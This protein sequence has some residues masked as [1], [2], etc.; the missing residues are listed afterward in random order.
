[1]AIATRLVLFLALLSVALPAI[2]QQQQR[3]MPR[4]SVTI[5]AGS[6]TADVKVVVSGDTTVEPDEP[7][8]VTISSP[9]LQIGTATA[10]GT[11]I[12]DDGI[13]APVLSVTAPTRVKN[14]TVANFTI[15]RSGDKAQADKVR[16]AIVPLGATPAAEDDFPAVLEDDFSGSTLGDE[17]CA[18]DGAMET[19][20]A[21]DGCP[22][23]PENA[24]HG[25]WEADLVSVS[26]G[27][28]RLS[29]DHDAGAWTS[30]Q[31]FSKRAFRGGLLR[32]AVNYPAGKGGAHAVWRAPEDHY[33]GPGPRSGQIVDS[34]YLGKTSGDRN[35][36][37][38]SQLQYSGPDSDAYPAIA[39]LL[40]DGTTWSGT[41]RA[42]STRW[43]VGTDGVTRFAFQVG[44]TE[45]W[46]PVQ[47]DWPPTQPWTLQ[48]EDEFGNPETIEYPGGGPA[49][50]FDRPFRLVLQA[51]VGDADSP[52]CT[53]EESCPD[54]S[55]LDGA[56][57]LVDFVRLYQ[58][59]TGEAVIQPGQDQAIVPVQTR[60]AAVAGVRNFRFVMLDADE[61]SISGSAGSADVALDPAGEPGVNHGKETYFLDFGLNAGGFT[62]SFGT[63][64]ENGNAFVTGGTAKNDTVTGSGGAVGGWTTD[65]IAPPTLTDPLVVENK[66][67][68]EA[69]WPSQADMAGK[70][71]RIIFPT[72][73]TCVLPKPGSSMSMGDNTYFGGTKT[74]PAHNIYITGG[75][76]ISPPPTP[77]TN[78]SAAG[79]PSGP[80][81]RWMDGIGYWEGAHVD[82]KFTCRDAL[83]LTTL[84]RYE[85]GITL[86]GNQPD[87][88]TPKIF[89]VNSILENTV[90]CGNKGANHGDTIHSQGDSAGSTRP[91]LTLQNVVL[92]TGAQGMFID[93]GSNQS[94]I[95]H[96]VNKLV[97]DHVQVYN[98]T[99]YTRIPNPGTF[100]DIYWNVAP[101]QGIWFYNTWL[102]DGATTSPS[103]SGFTSAGCA[104]YAS[105]AGVRTSGWCRGKNP[106]GDPVT[107]AN[108]GRYYSRAYFTGGNQP[109]DIKNARVPRLDHT[110]MVGA[111]MQIAIPVNTTRGKQRYVTLGFSARDET[112]AGQR[113]FDIAGAV[114]NKGFDIYGNAGARDTETRI[115][116]PV[117]VGD[118]GYLRLTLTGVT[119]QAQINWMS[120]QRPTVSVT[121]DKAVYNEGDTITATLRRS[122]PTEPSVSMGWQVLGAGDAPTTGFDFDPRSPSGTAFWGAGSV[123]Q[124]V[125]FKAVSDGTGE[126]QEGFVFA[127]TGGVGADIDPA[128]SSVTAAIAA[129]SGPTDP[130]APGGALYPCVD[131]CEP[132]GSKYPC[133]P[134]D[135]CAPGG[136]DYPCQ[137]TDECRPVGAVMGKPIRVEAGRAV[138]VRKTHLVSG[139][140]GAM[141]G[142]MTKCSKSTVCYGREEC[143]DPKGLQADNPS[144]AF[145]RVDTAGKFTDLQPGQRAIDSFLYQVCAPPTYTNCTPVIS[146]ITVT[147]PGAAPDEPPQPGDAEAPTTPSNLTAT[148]ASTSSITLAWG[149]ST[150]NVGVVGYRLSRCQGAGCTPTVVTANLTGTSHTT[151]GLSPAQTYCYR[152]AAF[153]AAG[154]VSQPTSTV[155]QTTNADPPVVSDGIRADMVPFAQPSQATLQASEKLVLAHWHQFPV[156]RSKT[157]PDGDWYSGATNL[158][159]RPLARPA[160]TTAGDEEWRIEDAMID[161]KW[162][163]QAGVN[164]FMLNIYRH[165]MTNP[166]AWPQLPRMLTAA[167]R[168]GKGFKIAP[169]F[170]CTYGGDSAAGTA[171]ADQYADFLAANGKTADPSLM[172]IGDNYL[173]GTY[174]ANNCDAA[175]YS[176]FKTR[177]SQRGM[178]VTLLCTMQGGPK[179]VAGHDGVCDA[180]SDWGERTADKAGI[181]WTARFAGVSGEPIAGV[182]SHGDV[183]YP[184]EGDWWTAEQRG[185]GSLRTSWDSART[186]GASWVQLHTWNDIAEHSHMYPT[187]AGQWAFY[188]L[189][190]YYIAWFKTGV[191]PTINKDA[192]YYSHRIAQTPVGTKMGIRH[193]PWYNEID[194]TA[195]LTAPAT[196]E[197]ITASGTTSQDLGAGLQTMKAPLPTSGKPRIR[198]IRNGVAVVNTESQFTVGAMPAEHDVIYRAGGS[199]RT[200]HGVTN[201]AATVCTTGTPDDCLMAPGEP[202]W[203]KE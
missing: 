109:P 137:P 57:A 140:S 198:V 118:D 130:C 41:S 59:P 43:R 60:D 53:G 27:N 12:N 19:Y 191:Q 112:A 189:N 193:L 58:Y 203:R 141:R 200:A 30:S 183:R 178:P 155:C 142:L 113:K 139:L 44:N 84:G 65:L 185:F 89:L 7:Y 55:T 170:D 114:V 4:G 136:A 46:A 6:T 147:A 5:P 48:S 173:V 127:L 160:R 106:K 69:G 37:W 143:A 33:Y 61:A 13:V 23:I 98:R 31:V 10:T 180:W 182:I 158:R 101:V 149:A 134:T 162:A 197:V 116:A 117:T 45:Y 132:G 148:A 50:P 32:Y 165:D 91:D 126:P 47:G 175:H 97:M 71:V 40:N 129:S 87:N 24:Q 110:R 187:T 157:G 201:P 42:A 8:A 115:T 108:V 107:P 56:M 99:D 81:F 21:P 82:M 181:N 75:H 179:Y 123:D 70:D 144:T 177:M 150:D 34:L 196:V 102:G 77:E 67:I 122:G 93:N 29:I 171:M 78:A 152:L 100:A 28:L 194:V 79:Y 26:G 39:G 3:V 17:W 72:D 85:G 11:I 76:F 172:K 146:N 174:W 105:S 131:P 2:A 63:T 49:S 83:A 80:T 188:D 133:E 159:L 18:A 94:Q 9:T 62:D 68:G 64:W 125:T 90:L 168:D 156:S 161:I 36:T 16:W 184:T 166:W 128:L 20:E 176:S 54:T 66:C 138:A 22:G 202:V 104:T 199:L 1:M 14:G 38:L 195:F 164:A 88:K 92:R 103:Q 35:K 111:T 163:R 51:S 192:I 135:P 95:G 190:A 52:A 121:L 73:R 151:T 25:T 124:K 154:N 96:G 167:G 120:I 145:V 153:D 119:G 86:R 169:N 186:T 15:R 74:N